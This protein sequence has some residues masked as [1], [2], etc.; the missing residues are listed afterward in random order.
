M[1]RVRTPGLL[2][3]GVLASGRGSNF[4]ALADAVA[5]GKLH[6]KIALVISDKDNAPVLEKAS[7][8]NIPSKLIMPGNFAKITDYENEI[9]QTLRSVNVDVVALAGY[10]RLIGKSFIESFPCGIVNIHPA[11]LPSFR[12]LHAPRQ[13]IEAGV[14]ISGCTV[15]IVDEGMDTGPIIMQAAVPIS[16]NDDENSL[17]ERILVEEHLVYWQALQLYAEGRIYIDKKNRVVI[18]EA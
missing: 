5:Q 1:I 10:M 2:T 6:A 11:L 4:E 8:A 7:A 14:R 15:H 16:Q 12:G 3:L 17:A 18:A 9:V 13:A